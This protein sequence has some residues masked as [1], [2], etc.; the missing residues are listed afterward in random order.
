[1]R[2]AAASHL[3]T[4]AKYMDRAFV[5]STMVPTSE[6]LAADSSEFVRAF[7]ATEINHLAPILGRDSAVKH[8]LPLLLLLLRDEN[9]EVLSHSASYY[10]GSA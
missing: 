5:V 6:R 1:M 10:N 3:S 8:I 9:S 2:A 4:V 7:F